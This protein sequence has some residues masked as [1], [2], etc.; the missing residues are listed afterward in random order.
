MNQP[1]TIVTLL[2]PM[3]ILFRHWRAILPTLACGW[4]AIAGAPQFR[5]AVGEE[6]DQQASD[7]CAP[8]QAFLEEVR[9][10]HGLPAVWAGKFWLDPPRR[11]VACSGVR[12][13][14]E[15]TA[16]SLEDCLHLGSCTKA[17]TATLIGCLVS[18]GKLRW[19]S[20]LAELLPDRPGLSSSPWGE[21]TV[22]QLMRHR[23]GLPANAP[24]WEL[25][26][27]HPHDPVAAR[28]AILDWMETLPR[29]TER[30]FEYS[31]AGYALLGHLAERLEG[32]SWEELMQQRI[33]V[34]LAIDRAGFGPVLGD[35]PLEQPWGHTLAPI[36]ASAGE[37]DGSESEPRKM[38]QW[39]PTH[40][41]NP[42][43]LGPAG[44]VHMPLHQWARFVSLFADADLPPTAL[45]IR[46]EDWLQLVTPGA[47]GEY[48]GGWGI[49]ERSWGGGKVLTHSGSN[50][51]W[52]CVAW[53]APQKK[54]V[55]LVATN[56]FA[57]ETP[58]ACDEIAA[59]LVN[60]RF[61][62]ACEP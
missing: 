51:T 34:P 61:D 14:G 40:L 18:A 13:F 45:P 33:F 4:L 22:E 29:P 46:D 31:N 39:R 30:K 21:V 1:C 53:V 43:P 50:T 16:V 25:H 10:R 52:Y 48:G 58:Q 24:W 36:A 12:K 20:S 8:V 5:L 42:P 41:D 35:H 60:G 9:T 38:P 3:A 32:E 15:A 19:D 54:F 28:A 56:C 17:M 47:N 11:V 44:R 2:H 62:S 49:T 55:V 37:Q 57:E 6:R 59:A 26:Q 23:S 7:G 27:R